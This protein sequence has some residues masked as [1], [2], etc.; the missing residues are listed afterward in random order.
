MLHNK[1]YTSL[2]TYANNILC[3]GRWNIFGYLYRFVRF[4]DDT[5]FNQ[6]EGTCQ[7]T[8][9]KEIKTKTNFLDFY[10]I[11]WD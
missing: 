6:I 4:M 3:I 5:K 10:E 2:H 7:K 11:W 1:H 8:T 9:I